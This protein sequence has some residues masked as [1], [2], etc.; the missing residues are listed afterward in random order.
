MT[1]TD[2][3]S[4]PPKSGRSGRLFVLDGWRAI[5]ILLVLGTHLLPLGPKNLRANETAGMVGMS[6]FF[7]LSGFLIAEQL[8]KRR[9]VAGF[10]VRRLFRIAP[11]AWIYATFVALFVGMGPIAWL[12]H[13]AFA[14]NYDLSALTPMTAHFWSLCVEVHFYLAI[15]L[16]MALTKFR[17]F[18]VLP[19]AWLTFFILRAVVLPEGSIQTHLR[20]DEI[21]SGS[22]LALIHL[23][24]FGPRPKALVSRLPSLVLTALLVLASHPEMGRLDAFRGLLASALIGHTLFREDSTRFN[25]LRHRFLRYIAEIS[26]ALYVIHPITTYGWL[27]SGSK[28]AKYVKRLL[29]FSLTFGLAH[30]STFN[31]EKRMLAIGKRLADRIEAGQT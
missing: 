3:K 31:F 18:L 14:V 29:S 20:V 2:Q 11:L 27:G 19:F 12:A 25:W 15:G 4:A 28:I 10:F 13:L 24:Y 5:S 1:A 22:C 21:L 17:G 23:G 30:L 9:N 26:Y 7:T 6:L 8:H 16:L